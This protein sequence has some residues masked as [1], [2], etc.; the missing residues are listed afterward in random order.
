MR[1]PFQERSGFTLIEIMVS[2]ALI[3]ILVGVY[4]M[5]ANPAGQLAASRNSERK[6]H[7]DAIL[8]AVESNISDQRNGQFSCAAGPVPAATST[9][10]SAPGANHYNIGPCLVPTYIATLPLDPS[11]SGTYFNS[12]TDYNTGYDI[13]INASGTLITLSAPAAE[14]NQTI[15][16]SGW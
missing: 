3:T 13:S 14:L 16:V 7:L 5:V 2:I 12:V 8:N 1:D 10:M 6:F 4:F 11:A 15:S 9:M